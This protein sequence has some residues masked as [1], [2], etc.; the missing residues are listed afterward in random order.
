MD[1]SGGYAISGHDKYVQ[2]WQVTTTQTAGFDRIWDR[3]VDSQKKSAVLD[4][5]RVVFGPTTQSGLGHP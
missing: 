1:A 4:H 5:V 2:L 3:K